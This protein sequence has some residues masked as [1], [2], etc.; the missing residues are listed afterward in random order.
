MTEE[1]NNLGKVLC[2]FCSAPWS[3]ENIR[4]GDLDAGDHCA[5]GRFYGEQMTVD[6]T[7]HE[8]NRLIYRKEGA[9]VGTYGLTSIG[10]ET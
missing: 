6:I 8:C 7:C 3:E 4:T 10:E 1:I 9:A 5:S 2:P